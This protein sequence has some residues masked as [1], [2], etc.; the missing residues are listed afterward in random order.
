MNLYI[1]LQVIFMSKKLMAIYLTFDPKAAA[2]A[3][4]L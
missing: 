4:F 3:L 2:T 1:F